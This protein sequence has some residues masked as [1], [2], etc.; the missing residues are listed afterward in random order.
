MTIPSKGK[1]IVYLVMLFVLGAVTG[2]GITYKLVK[3]HPPGRGPGHPPGDFTE[4]MRSDLKTRLNLTA[5]Q[6][7]KINPMIDVAGAELRSIQTNTMQRVSQVFDN[8]HAQMR[9]LLTDEQKTK[10]EEMEKEF[11][12]RRHRSRSG[13]P[14]TPPGSAGQTNAPVK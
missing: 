4:R 7:D 2:S 1:L 5:D 13:H 3:G 10:L 12:E 11:R 9:P 6:V 14:E 8:L